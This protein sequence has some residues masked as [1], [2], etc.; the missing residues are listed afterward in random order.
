MP[1][2]DGLEFPARPD[3]RG[4]PG[5]SP[6]GSRPG[7]PG[8]AAAPDPNGADLL[9]RVASGDADAVREMV[10]R[11]RKPLLDLGVRYLRDRSEAEDLCQDVFLQVLKAAST[12]RGS[13]S[14]RGWVFRIA[15]NLAH[16]RLRRTRLPV[17]PEPDARPSA[18]GDPAEGLLAREKARAVREAVASLPEKQR[19]AVILL[20][21]ECLSY[22][23]VAEALEVTLPAAVSI[24][25]RAHVALRDLL[26]NFSV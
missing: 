24:I 14:A 16:N 15:A 22:A 5:G 6:E 2:P 7:P 12:F 8:E 25:H 21:H 10:E 1:E 20:R 9:G 4:D 17:D 19:L 11:Y 23:E 3:G 18:V 13:G 26:K